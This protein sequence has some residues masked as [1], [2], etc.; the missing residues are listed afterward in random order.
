LRKRGLLNRFLWY[1]VRRSKLL[2]EGGA[3]DPASL[4]DFSRRVAKAVSEAQRL[5]RLHWSPFTREVWRNVYP[6]LSAARPGLL[7]AVIS[8]AEAQTV[9]LAV[10]YA[11]LRGSNEISPEDLTAALAA[12]NYC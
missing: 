12:W 5:S 10:I 9:R 2:P 8:R 7:G 6:A 11:A 1:C 4:A 3:L